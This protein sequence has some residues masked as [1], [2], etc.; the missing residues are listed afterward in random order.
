[1]TEGTPKQ[2]GISMVTRNYQ[3]W[4]TT[5]YLPLSFHLEVPM[6]HEQIGQR[7]RNRT[8]GFVEKKKRKNT[9]KINDDATQYAVNSQNRER[10]WSISLL[11]ARSIPFMNHIYENVAV[12]FSIRSSYR[13][14]IWILLLL[15]RAW[16]DFC[17]MDGYEISLYLSNNCHPFIYLN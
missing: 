7:F 13:N 9:Q 6:R 4:P 3:G 8:V 14:D 5:N 1:M 2:T 16:K 15:Y 10:S 17:R 11:L 12:V